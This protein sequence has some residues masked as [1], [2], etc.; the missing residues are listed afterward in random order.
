MSLTSTDSHLDA[1]MRQPQYAT[2]VES[3][4]PGP[5]PKPP[6]GFPYYC[7]TVVDDTTAQLYRNFPD[8]YSV[9]KTEKGEFAIFQNEKRASIFPPLGSNGERE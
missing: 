3:Q 2:A 6:E 4:D 9:V 8:L 7:R 5:R 1:V